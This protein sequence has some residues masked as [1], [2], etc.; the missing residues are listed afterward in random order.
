[1]RRARL[2]EVSEATSQALDAIAGRLAEEP[3]PN[4]ELAALQRE[5]VAGVRAGRLDWAAIHAHEAAFDAATAEVQRAQFEALWALHDALRPDQRKAVVDGIGTMMAAQRPTVAPPPQSTEGLSSHVARRLE[6]MTTELDLDPTQ[7]EDVAR[8][9]ALRHP[10]ANAGDAQLR[11]EAADRQMQA[12]LAAFSGDVFSLRESDL[13]STTGGPV[14]SFDR[15]ATFVEH[16]LPLLR[17]DQVAA[18][19]ESMSH[20]GRPSPPAPGRASPDP[21]PNP[22]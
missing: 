6:Q 17:P 4:P 2:A 1:V 5:L 8:L 22:H 7:A 20:K 21:D 10:A 9:L 14:P 12:V 19:E 15:E 11:A 18:L 13:A 16:L 3:D